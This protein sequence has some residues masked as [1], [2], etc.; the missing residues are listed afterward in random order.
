M[1]EL[2]RQ[3]KCGAKLRVLYAGVQRAVSCMGQKQEN[4]GHVL[5]LHRGPQLAAQRLLGSAQWRQEEQLLVLGS[6]PRLSLLPEDQE[7]NEG[8]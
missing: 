8:L 1:S 5:G 3:V 7:S 6:Y 4:G 2:G